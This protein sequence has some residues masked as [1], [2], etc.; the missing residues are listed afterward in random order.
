MI[1]SVAEDNK[2]GLTVE[3]EEK[4][5]FELMRGMVQAGIID[6]INGKKKGD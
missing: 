2:R 3:K 5:L 4:F 6:N 1:F